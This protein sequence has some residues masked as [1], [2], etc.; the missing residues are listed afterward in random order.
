MALQETDKL[1]AFRNGEHYK[2]SGTEIIDLVSNAL[3]TSEHS[4]ED[5]GERDTLIASS[6][7]SNGDSIYVK[8]ASADVTVATGWAIYR[9]V[10]KTPLLLSKI[11]SEEDLDVLI[12]TTDLTVTVSAT[13]MVIENSDGTDAVLP[14]ATPTTAGLMSPTHVALLGLLSVTGAVDLDAL[15]TDSHKKAFAGGTATTNP[16]TVD[17]TTQEIGFDIDALDPLP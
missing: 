14:V 8:D 10:T 15:A 12:T 9:V 3:G 2:F 6:A 7:I 5:I 16:I 17:A 11:A 13:N 4:V 1:L